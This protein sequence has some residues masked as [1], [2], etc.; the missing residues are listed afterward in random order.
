[1]I[2]NHRGKLQLLIYFWI[3]NSKARVTVTRGRHMS[4]VASACSKQNTAVYHTITIITELS[5][6]AF[7]L[8]DAVTSSRCP[9]RLCVFTV[10]FLMPLVT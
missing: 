4:Q 5:I 9:T 8:A 6:V 7:P 2:D 3:E 10:S 1:M